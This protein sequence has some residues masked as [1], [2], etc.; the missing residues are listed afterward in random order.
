MNAPEEAAAKFGYNAII[1]ANDAAF[2][3]VLGY[4]ESLCVYET[5]QFTDYSR[6]ECNMFDGNQRVER[7]KTIFPEDLRKAY[8]LG[9]RLVEKAKEGK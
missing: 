1:S 8:E 5:M 3:R 4:N 6:Y 2:K 7:N 9:A